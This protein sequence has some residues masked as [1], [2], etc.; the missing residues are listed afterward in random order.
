M[1]NGRKFFLDQHGCAKNQVDG[2]IITTQLESL[3]Y[4]KTDNSDEADFIIVNSCGFISSAKEESINSV[5]DFRSAY[6][7]KKI[8]L[9]GCLAERYAD[10]FDT[11]MPEADGFFGNGDLSQ[12]GSV[13]TS[14]FNGERPVVKPEQKGV[15]CA[16]R[17]TLLS[18][19]GSAYVKITEGC[20]NRCTFCAIPIIRGELRSRKCDEI[21]SEIQDLVEKHNV[22]EINLIGQDLAAFGCGKDDDVTGSGKNGYDSIYK[23]LDSPVI[24]NSD[25]EKLNGPSF[26]S[27]LVERI[28]QIKGDFWVRLLYIHPDHFNPDLLEA[29][30]KD[31]RFLPYFD[32]PFQSGDDGI[33][34]RMNR[35]GSSK[36]YVQLVNEIRNVF[37][38]ACIRTTFLTGFPGEDEVSFENTKNFLSAIQ[39]DWSGC[40]SYSLEEGTPAEKFKGRV[41]KKT[42]EKRAHELEKIQS[43]ITIKRLNERIGK[44]Y[45]VLVEEIIENKAGTDEGLAIGRAWFD[46]PEVD[47]NFVIRYDLDDS[48]AVSAI[49][50][51]AMVKAKA[52]ASSEVDVDGVY[53]A[54]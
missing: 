11:E 14:L 10:V 35:K 48:S 34:K 31:S 46:A 13:V 27:M 30:K 38:D 24:E 40:F 3:G 39:S 8:L 43:E 15:C 21:V 53:V 7:D 28:S 47:G 23:N 6:P 12:I 49:V 45:D 1:G 18:F 9:A 42:A 44:V 17:N 20:N 54:G 52:L 51:G 25:F 4:I 29:M 32:I 2:E 37:P 41:P 22:R 19:K 5:M 16:D 50:P 26:L 36:T 33:I